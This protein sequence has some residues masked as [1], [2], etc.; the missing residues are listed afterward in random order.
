M[1]RV[2]VVDDDP[3]TLE[4]FNVVL[5]DAG[6]EVRAAATGE[7]ALQVARCQAFELILLD[8]G[9]PD[10]TGTQVLRELRKALIETPVVIMTGFGSVPSAVEAMKLGAADYV[11]KPLI[12]DDLIR[13]VRSACAGSFGSMSRNRPHGGIPTVV[14]RATILDARIQD[15]IRI[16]EREFGAPVSLEDL[17]ARVGL[18]A[19]R[20]RHLFRETVGVSLARLRRERR[21]DAAA[22]LLIRTH[23]RVSEIC[24]KVGFPNPVLFDK[25]FRRRFGLSPK[26]Y[27][28]RHQPAG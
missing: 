16:I 1:S 19:S 28:R 27:R 9:L 14:D 3:G 10:L 17:A 20:L 13:L 4:T 6:F 11:E 2:L 12:G 26:E 15:V 7:A 8:L 22:G 5:R 25:A 18:G 21:L 24:Y 23:N